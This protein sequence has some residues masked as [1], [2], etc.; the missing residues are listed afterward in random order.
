HHRLIP[1]SAIIGGL[2]TL[3]ADDLA[4]TLM[5]PYELP[6]GLITSLVGGSFFLYLIRARQRSLRGKS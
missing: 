3:L 6:V 5:A 2:L 1:A 4:R